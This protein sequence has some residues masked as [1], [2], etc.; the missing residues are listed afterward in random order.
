MSDSRVFVI[1]GA[2]SGIGAATAHRAVEAGYRVVLGARSKDK[3]DALV[4]ALGGAS[5]ALAVTTDVTKWEDN[6]ALIAAAQD[7][8]GSVDVVFANAG[9]GAARGWLN[10]TPEHWHDMVLTN[11]LGAAYTVRAAIPALKATKGHVLLT[12]SVAGR[13][14]LPGSLYSS[15]KW[16]VTG[17]SESI[18]QDLNGTG[19]RTTLISPGGVETPFFDNPSQDRLE[20]DDIARAVLYAVS[21]PPHVDINEIFVRPIAQEG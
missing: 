1:T 19:V 20:P 7:T 16:A 13:K 6:E 5:H 11:V 10:E 17:M 12:G 15:T 18:R 14:A 4:E 9:F 2:S 3:L 21:Q 8:F